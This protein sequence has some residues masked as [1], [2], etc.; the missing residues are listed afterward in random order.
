MP[1]KFR[2]SLIVASASVGAL[3]AASLAA[4]P[5][6]AEEMLHAG[7]TAIVTAVEA[8]QAA[9][10]L[11]GELGY[12]LNTAASFAYRIGEVEFVDDQWQVSLSFRPDRNRLHQWKA[13][14][15]LV[16][17]YTAEIEKP[18]FIKTLS[19]INITHRSPA[20]SSQQ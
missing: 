3:F 12:S 9:Q 18:D 20:T 4:A 17:R 1:Y 13:G 19:L 6:T 14:V 10:G 2:Y 11:M 7:D 5:A 8:K 16:N 15:V